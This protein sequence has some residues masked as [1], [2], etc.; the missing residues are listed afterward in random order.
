MTIIR[1]SKEIRCKNIYDILFAVYGK[2]NCPLSYSTP[3]QLVISVILSAQCM[4]KRVNKTVPSLYA[5]YPDSKTL[6]TAELDNVEKIIKPIGL[7]HAKARNI[8]AAAKML[9]EK[10]SGIIP[11]SID[12]LLTLPGVGRKTANAI[13]SHL[14]NGPGF[15]VD[16]HV[17]RVLNR[18]GIVSTKDPF[19]I[20]MQIK[21]LLPAEK[22]GNFSL[23]LI[24]HGRNRCKARSPDCDICEI[25]S[26]CLKRL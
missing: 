25:N 14:F 17:N 1:L 13:I 9:E 23:L 11:D 19:K 20:E 7:H 10:F 26:L 15:A 5:K 18:I 3:F 21:K 2:V 6:S 12:K 4:D 16:T 22:L 24:M 8:I